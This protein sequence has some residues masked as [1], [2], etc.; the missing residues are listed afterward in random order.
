[1]KFPFPFKSASGTVAAAS[2]LWPTCVDS[3][4]TPSFRINTGGD[5][6]FGVSSNS[7][8]DID[9]DSKEVTGRNRSLASSIFSSESCNYTD[10]HAEGLESAVVGGL[11]SER[12]FFEPAG[13]TKSIL[14][15][16]KVIEDCTDGDGDG[17][18][19]V[20][21]VA[22]DSD[23]PYSDFRTSMEE[24]VEAHGLKDWEYL[25][26]LLACYL[27]INCEIHHSY[28]IE[29]FL[30]LLIHLGMVLSIE[31]FF[32][33]SAVTAPTPISFTSP[34]SFSSPSS[35]GNEEHS[36]TVRNIPETS[37]SSSSSSSMS[38][39]L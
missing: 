6:L 17:D 37:S 1:M 39:Y 25:E 26:E 14:E 24:M 7:A 28:I 29:A 30:D 31:E 2:R 11:K 32:S 36:R 34:L 20:K 33:P 3:P 38:S 16:A 13:E 9:G 15:E 18:G 8:A 22:M 10:E 27:R 21:V 5:D 19:G 35:P 4:R 12:L 23:D